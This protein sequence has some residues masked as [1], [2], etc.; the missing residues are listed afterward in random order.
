[1][2][3]GDEATSDTDS[4]GQET[5]DDGL[6]GFSASGDDELEVPNIEMGPPVQPWAAIQRA[7]FVDFHHWDFGET[8]SQ[9]GS[10]MR[11]L[12]FWGSTFEET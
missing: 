5:E 7:G 9:R 2:P 6:E 1:M 11:S 8:V 10:L 12:F 4:V 3:I